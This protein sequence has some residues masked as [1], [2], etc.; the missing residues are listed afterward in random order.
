MCLIPELSPFHH[1]WKRAL[2]VTVL[3][4]FCSL[5]NLPFTYF[6]VYISLF[7]T[8]TNHPNTQGASN[9]KYLPSTWVGH[10][11]KKE[12]VFPLVLDV[13]EASAQWQVQKQLLDP[14]FFLAQEEKGCWEELC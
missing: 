2:A 6:Y 8:Q 1:S 3:N 12:R 14:E 10:L 13:M 9:S 11:K 4:T 7:Q 5:V